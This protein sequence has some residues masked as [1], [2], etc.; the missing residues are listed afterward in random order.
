VKPRGFVS[1]DGFRVAVG[2]QLVG[3]VCTVF[4]TG[5][6]LLIFYRHYLVRE[7]D[8]DRSRRS[9]N[10]PEPRRRDANRQRLLNDLLT[11]AGNPSNP[12]LDC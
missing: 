6:H 12:A 8:I 4:A 7:L 1:W 10:L 5:D 3:R 11:T 2:Y 9:Q